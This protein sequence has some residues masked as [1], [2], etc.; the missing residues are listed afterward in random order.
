MLSGFNFN[1]LERIGKIAGAMKRT[2]RR[3]NGTLEQA[4]VML[5]QNQA[6]FM[7]NQ[8]AKLTLFNDIYARLTRIEKDLEQIKAILLRHNQIL[9]D[10]PESI[11]RKVGFKTK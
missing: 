2:M 9:N 5:I 10:L 1:W 8:A 3:T 4:V 11:R 7:Q 6:A